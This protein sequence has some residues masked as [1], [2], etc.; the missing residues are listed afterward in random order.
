MTQDSD[1]KPDADKPRPRDT[2]LVGKGWEILA[3]GAAN[4]FEKG[5]EDPFDQALLEQLR[6]QPNPFASDQEADQVIEEATAM[7]TTPAEAPPTDAFWDRGRGAE[8]SGP[9][10]SPASALEAE[11]RDLS[12]EEL[13]TLF[14]APEPAGAILTEPGT[15]TGGQNIMHTPDSGAASPLDIPG[16][17]PS[18]MTSAEL[19]PAEPVPVEALP[20]ISPLD[21][22]MIPIAP[23]E[24]PPPDMAPDTTS[25]AAPS[26]FGADI[27]AQFDDPF[28][29][30]STKRNG[31]VEAKISNDLST[32]AAVESLLITDARLN[33]L[34][35]MIDETYNIVVN[36]VRGYYDST[37]EAL[38]DLKKAREYLLAGRE[39]YD[40]AEQMVMSVKARLRLEEK[41]RVWS[42]TRGA[43]LVVYLVAWLLFLSISSLA[44][45]YLGI[46][47]FIDAH[48]P[49]WMAG[50]VLPTLFGALG[51]VVGALWVLIKHIA[52]DRDFDPIHTTWYLTNP[53]MGGALGVLS[54]FIL[55]FSGS[56]ITSGMTGTAIDFNQPTSIIFQVILLTTCAIIGFRQN[57]F[58]ELIERFLKAVLPKKAE[59]EAPP[60]T[61][62][63]AVG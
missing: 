8:A 59:E 36:D 48:V 37:E 11:P 7:N 23:T 2:S 6:G 45:Y 4:P 46:L 14:S 17:E 49:A 44:L 27:T 33:R 28:A 31:Q 24:P 18:D 26:M 9:S 51:G 62:P 3:G 50:T 40:N 54:Y 1:T 60:A 38:A 15:G 30:I 35:D 34:W 55:G 58:W 61:P 47:D 10:A 32:D 16:S 22:A 57:V 43:W 19:V 13:G 53:L 20:E 52:R 5:G 63:D 39:Y 42:R 29:G 56:I 12:P 25:K 41:V 21:E